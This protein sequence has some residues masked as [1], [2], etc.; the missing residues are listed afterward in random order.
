MRLG[1]VIPQVHPWR[2]LSA[3]FRWAEEVGYDVAYVYDHLTHPT[4]EGQW[5]A[6][7]F[8]TLGAAAMTTKTI[9]LGTLVASATLHSPVS[10]AR[11]AATVQDLSGGRLVL[12]LGAGSPRCSAADRG[13]D[14]TP[15]EMFGRLAD[16]VRGLEA[17]WGGAT[18]WTGETRSFKGLQT[19]A[20]P[21]GAEK[22]FLMLA[23]HG[24]KALALAAAHA[25]GWNTYGGPN[26]VNL[27][28]GEFWVDLARQ[29]HRFEEACSV[30]GR[31][32]FRS[33]LL[34]YGQVRPT[35]SVAA[36]LE[37]ADRAEGLGFDELVVYG[38]GMAGDMFTS[39][40]D[41]HER[42]I[43]RIHD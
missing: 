15:R 23:A 22:P 31:T 37:A 24:P 1:V 35:T 18:E 11:R 3:S 20:L 43:E 10:L 41:V 19:T 38:P 42:A 29:V 5:L 4:A 26:N 12:G 17:V 8:T 13:E 39:D 16:V 30:T 40:P 21:D 9:G 32:L 28:A 6:D 27:D 7:G 36:F 2:E 25:D 33:L 34:G 14:P